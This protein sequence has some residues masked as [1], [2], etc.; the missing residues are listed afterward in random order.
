MQIPLLEYTKKGMTNEDTICAI[1]TP[2]GVGGIAVIRVSG[3]ES[4]DIADSIWKG[5]R[6][7]DV[8]S[9]TVHLGT[10]I[11]D[12]SGCKEP[13]D[14]AVATI[15]R[16]P[17]S[18]TGENV[19]EFSV[20]GSKYVQR[21]LINLLINHGCRLAEAG[22]FTR[23]AFSAGQIDLAQAEGVADVIASTSRSAHR[24]AVSQMR[25]DFSSKLAGLR[26][27][28]LELSALL[29]L[30]LDFSE[31]DVEFASRKHL[32]ELAEEAHG[33]V[34][35]LASTF[36][37]GAAIR[38]GIPVAIIG[39]T[40]TG[41][42]T[43]LNTLLHDDRAIVSEIH[44]TT[45]DIVED[46]IDIGGTLFR[47]IDTAGLRD[48]S[49]EV[50]SIGIDRALERASRAKIILWMT[51]AT[52]TC[53]SIRESYSRMSSCL[54]EG[55][56]M[57]A[58]VNKIDAISDPKKLEEIDQTISGLHPDAT[59]IH[60][61]AKNGHGL[62]DLSS[63]L[64]EYAH[65]NESDGSD[66]IVTNARHYQAL[67]LASDSLSHTIDGL[68]IGLSG[69]FIAQDL[70]ETLHHLGSIT[71]TLTTPDILSTIFTRFCIGK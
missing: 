44:G 48:T 11:D 42:S 61:S 51:D 21:Q 39:R 19:V 31:E 13:L 54:S 38:D 23:R 5:A 34:T 68:H 6:L 20:H 3:P 58:V 22:E 8:P 24:L 29:E 27:R 35:R 50:E 59:M 37:R 43:L 53:D 32:L 49:D 36:S 40:N 7:A 26:E 30:E 46:T 47:I 66:I 28:L 62:T 70:R 16:S 55:Q 2:S 33:T 4:I 15:F 10:I 71:G 65:G 45:R 17:H 69:D 63:S 9:H 41:K 57:I 14:Q 60:I 18:Y 56:D 1:S 12:T 25:G 64:V 52:D 67:K